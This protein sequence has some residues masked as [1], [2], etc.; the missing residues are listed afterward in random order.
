MAT[1]EEWLELV[2]RLE[3]RWSE[4]YFLDVDGDLGAVKVELGDQV[5]VDLPE[6]L[7]PG[8]AWV[9]MSDGNRF[10]L[11]VPSNAGVESPITLIL[12]WKGGQDH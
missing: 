10:I 7:F 5:V 9:N 6:K 2:D 11:G 8:R 3:R 1:L 12:N 4:L